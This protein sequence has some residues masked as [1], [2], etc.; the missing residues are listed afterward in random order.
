VFFSLRDGDKVPA[1]VE[2]ARTMA[3]CGLKIVATDG[4]AKFLRA[5]GI[6]CERVNKVREGRPHVVDMI[7]NSDINLVINTPSGKYPRQDESAIRSTSW[8][9]KVPI[10]TTIQG[11]VATA[12]AIKRL[13]E[14]EM[15]VKTLQEYTIDT[16]GKVTPPRVTT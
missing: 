13:Q 2:V 10:V 1:A 16:H 7:L 9:R 8:A 5:G 11:A 4:T 14:T 12:Q 15:S 3:K 6:Q